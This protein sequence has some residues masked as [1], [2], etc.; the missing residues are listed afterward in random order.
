VVEYLN[1]ILLQIYH[2]VCQWKNY[3][4]RLTFGKVMGKS[5]VS[6]FFWDTV[7]NHAKFYPNQFRGFGSAHAWFRAP[8]HKVT[9]LFFLVL[10]KGYSRDAC[11]DFDAKYAKRRGSAQGSAFWG[12]RNQNLRFRPPF[13]P[14]TAILGPISTGLW[15][16]FA[17]KRL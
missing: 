8:Q 6:C 2:W 1:T 13:S 4:N 11:T 3:E 17:R 9:R 12:S 15:I 14:K 5:L 10:E 7:Y 16:F